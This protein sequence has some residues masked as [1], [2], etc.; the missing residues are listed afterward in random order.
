MLDN[1]RAV[2]AV[3]VRQGN[4]LRAGFIDAHVDEAD[5]VVETLAEHGGGDK[6]DDFWRGGGHSE[7]ACHAEVVF[8]HVY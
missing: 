7:L 1:A 6:R 5:V 8:Q 3:N 4:G 2:H